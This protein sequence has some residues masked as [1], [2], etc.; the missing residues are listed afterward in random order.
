LFDSHSGEWVNHVNLALW[1]DLIVLAP[2]TAN[3]LSALINGKADSA[4]IVT[5]MCARCPVILVPAMDHDMWLH[6]TTK[7]NIQRAKEIGFHIIE[8]DY[9]AL[10]SGLFGHGRMPEP[11]A[12]I[13]HLSLF[14]KLNSWWTGKRI[15]IS[16]GG[17]REPLDPVRYISNHSSG[18]M[19]VALAEAAYSNG[20]LVTLV[21]TKGSK[22]PIFQGI[23]CIEVE[24]AIEMQNEMNQLA[25]NQDVIAMAAAVA[26]Y[27][28]ANVESQKIKKSKSGFPGF[29][30]VENPDILKGLAAS[31][32][33]FFLLGFALESNGS[34]DQAKI[35]FKQ[36]GVDALALNSLET[37]GAGF[38]VDTN[39][40]T[41]IT[42]DS[43]KPLDLKSKTEI[44]VEILNFVAECNIKSR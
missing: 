24:T 36:K 44:A 15:L 14:K 34:I 27:R 33:N 5:A 17:T 30:W 19:G 28:I 40:I 42:S 6:A 41:L 12:L 23:H 20:A 25:E 2:L 10:A 4:P 29:E 32:R 8:P 16:S 21:R 39:K 13:Q 35:K 22:V 38:E 3:S 7:V 18:K 43:I 9:G 11:A 37:P 1:A 26:D 31:N